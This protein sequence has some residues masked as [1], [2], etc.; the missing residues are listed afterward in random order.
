MFLRG[1]IPAIFE[2]SEPL[3]CWL[4]PYIERDDFKMLTVVFSSAVGHLLYHLL[5]WETADQ[6]LQRN[7]RNSGKWIWLSMKSCLRA[8][9]DSCIALY[10]LTLSSK[11]RE[12]FLN[13]KSCVLTVGD[14]SRTTMQT[15]V[16][17]TTAGAPSILQDRYYT[18]IRRWKSRVVKWAPPPFSSCA[19]GRGSGPMNSVEL[20]L[21]FG[22]KFKLCKNIA[23]QWS[24][25]RG[26]GRFRSRVL[27]V[28]LHSETSQHPTLVA[29]TYP[30]Y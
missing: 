25:V 21:Y 4:R 5:Q 19:Y 20:R 15:A 6:I 24:G 13:G 14:S 7:T 27:I 3:H 12:V 2:S 1:L 30:A 29:S 18:S 9:N 11:G 22:K 16:R 10:T 28:P 8:L 17:T 23:F 26:H